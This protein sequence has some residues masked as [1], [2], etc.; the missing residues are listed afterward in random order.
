MC[1]RRC[2]SRG[3]LALVSDNRTLVALAAQAQED[4]RVALELAPDNDV[5]HHLFGRWVGARGPVQY[6]T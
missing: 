3:R 2:V 5:A 6:T 4:A 1:G